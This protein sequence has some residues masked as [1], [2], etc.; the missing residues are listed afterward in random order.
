PRI[1]EGAGGRAPRP[2]RGARGGPRALRTPAALDRVLPAGETLSRHS[3]RIAAAP[4]RVWEAVLGADL[5]SS[6][7]AKSLLFLR[8]YGRR[9][10]PTGAGAFPRGPGALRLPPR[11]REPRGGRGF[12][13]S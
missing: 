4:E 1:P 2:P 10:F 9:A 11:P 8:G 6:S 13:V 5:A 3:I 12:C 7:A